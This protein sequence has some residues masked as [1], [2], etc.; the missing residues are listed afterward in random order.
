[1]IISSFFTE[2]IQKCGE[3]YSVLHC[4][5]SPRDPVVVPTS[6]IANLH[7]VS[8]CTSPPADGVEAISF[9]RAIM[10]L[11]DKKKIGYQLISSLHPLYDLSMHRF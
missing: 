9:L 8:T 11:R 3:I 5:R 4:Q 2:F 1:M 10:H 7:T 6:D